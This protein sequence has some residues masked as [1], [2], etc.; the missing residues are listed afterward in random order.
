MQMHSRARL[1]KG[2]FMA[3]FFLRGKWKKRAVTALSIALSLTFSI[4]LLSACGGSASDND[5]DDD[6]DDTA[7]ETDTQL[8]QNGNFE[9]YSDKEKKRED[10][11][12]FLYS[13]ANWSFTSGSPSSDTQSGIVNLDEWD[14]LTTSTYRLVEDDKEE[15]KERDAE[16]ADAAAAIANAIA[17]WEEASIY[18]RL[19]F[20][21]KYKTEVSALK[22]GT[23]EK[24]HFDKYNYS[25][26]FEDV[27]MLKDAETKKELSTPHA[28]DESKKDENHLLMIHNHR[29]QDN[30]AGTGQYY[31]SGTTI[32][33]PAGTA[34][35]VSVSVR[36]SELYHYYYDG[37]EDNGVEVTARAGAYIGVTNTVGGTTL[38][39][40]QI[41][42]IITKDEW[43]TYTL[44]IRAN[45]YA[46]STFRIVLGLGQSTSD[47]RYEAVNGFAFF[48]DVNCKLISSDE[49]D[50]SAENV[51]TEL[52]LDS[53]KGEKLIVSEN[54]PTQSYALDLK[55]DEGFES[56]NFEQDGVEIDLTSETSGSQEYKSLIGDNRTDGTP[57]ERSSIVEYTTVSALRANPTGN[58]YLS[59][60][61]SKDFNSEKFP[62][63]DENLI[64]LLSTNGAAYTAKLPTVTVP[65]GEKMLLSFFVKTSS[66]RTGKTGASAI[67]VDGENETAISAFDSTTVATVDIDD[68]RK[69]IYDGWVQCFF[70][71]ENET[72][73]EKDFYVK[74]CYG[75]TSIASSKTSDYCDGYA[76]FA[77][78]QTV[79]GDNFT[80]TK[81]NYASTGNYAKKVSL[82][83]EVTPTEKFADVSVTS[84]IEK[85]LAT[86]VGFTGVQSGSANMVL[87]GTTNPSQAQLNEKGL[88]TGLLNA[89][90]AKNYNGKEWSALI[91]A[92]SDPTSTD[93][94][95]WKNTFGD[96]DKLSTVANQPLVIANTSNSAQPA[97]G[98]FANRASVS[99]NSYQ[100]ISMNVKLSAGAKAYIYLI[101]TSDTSKP[102]NE[103][104]KPSVPK[105][106][107]WYDDEGNI[108]R[109]DPSDESL[110]ST[111]SKRANILFEK[112]SNGLYTRAGETNG[113]YYAN[114]HNYEKDENG[115]L[116]NEKD[117]IVYY[118][119]KDRNAFFAYFD[120]DK[121]GSAAYSQI[122]TNLPTELEFDGKTE[123]ITR[124]SPDEALI[125]KFGSVIEVIGTEETKDT[126][127]EVAFYVHT[128][129]AAK[130][131]RLE[132]WAGERTDTEAGIPAN[133]YYFFDNYKSE[134]VSNYADILGERVE[135]IK[136]LLNGTKA[137]GEEGY[138]GEKDNLPDSYAAY[139]TFT[140]YD[141]PTYT[142]YDSTLDIDKLGDPHGSYKQSKY[143]EQLIA[144][145]YTSENGK[146]TEKFID[147]SAYNV[148]VPEDDLGKT[149]E[150][151]EDEETTSTGTNAWL[152]ISSG[153][154]AGALIFVILAVVI[155]R[156]VKTAKKNS[157]GKTRAAKRSRKKA[158][159][160]SE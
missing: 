61:M 4:G 123:K 9:F 87:N 114:L 2:R 121:T 77:N 25:I 148:D 91:G 105:V 70:F 30:V 103:V 131:Y 136:D 60:I 73:T 138:Y 44:Y 150:D 113:T 115:N 53:K 51:K 74:L 5:D 135:E 23:D 158:D 54:K 14:D 101:D 90:Y 24:K 55:A 65:A 42:N 109:I 144:L 147:Y 122:V 129:S 79:D 94:S 84:D 50:T 108:C 137:P 29:K 62:F 92:S 40:M 76:A 159:R 139:S 56:L 130:N 49:Y 133:S 127:H 157:S 15:E 124:Y 119:D 141:S 26:D 16:A 98:F 97:Y 154:T 1:K 13:P 17:H 96:K 112:Q 35:E 58:G 142:R 41:K 45:T 63:K 145:N 132:I 66:V 3:K 102:F 125:S 71:V 120:E 68:T 104:L 118:Y 106:T 31:T 37:S 8:L 126:W 134:S 153:V 140:F 100:K 21:D 7:T 152:L 72:E 80:A 64:M 89:K 82:T 69:D 86:P 39:Q 83:G 93:A 99:A 11:R 81:Y 22:S 6:D 117:E 18:D 111:A 59:G 146:S 143:T 36:T 52:T 32:T 43:Q 95:W 67:L 128:G 85:G 27:K 78:F 48:D 47:N 38:D 33:L 116:V 20:L 34:A 151:E 149:D 10:K 57:A 88:F 107:Y 160:E 12:T 110:K 46:T 155:R 19:E 75:P 28:D 156:I